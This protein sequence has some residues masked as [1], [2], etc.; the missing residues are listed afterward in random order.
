MSRRGRK[1]EISTDHDSF[2]DI[3]ANIVG[4]LIILVVLVGVRAKHAPVSVSVPGPKPAGGKSASKDDLE[5]ERALRQDLIDMQRRGIR[6]A[7]EAILRDRQRIA[8]AMR[9]SAT[10]RKIEED[11]SQ[12]DAQAQAEYDLQLK[13]AEE[14]AKL[15]EAIR[16]SIFA[17]QQKEGAEP[18]ELEFNSTPISHTVHGR[19]LHLLLQD[20]RVV[21]VPF[22]KLVEQL[23]MEFDRKVY[24]LQHQRLFTDK[25]G[26]IDGF[27]LR[28]TLERLDASPELYMQTGRSG[29]VPR[30]RLVEFL[31]VSRRLGETV[32]V[33]IV[34]G[35][36]LR[37]TLKRHR[38]DLTTVTIWTYPD[39]FANYQRLKNMLYQLGFP[40]AARP[41]QFGVPISA[42]PEGSH[43][44]AQYSHTPSRVQ[45]RKTIEKRNTGAAQTTNRPINPRIDD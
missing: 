4:I 23:E 2:L 39:G 14:Q 33:A 32:D 16:K 20:S 37:Q 8:L 13:L 21:V 45:L 27:R 7:D 5:L 42:S 38:P 22:D 3:V 10:E 18:V 25:L 43:S 12:L 44:A 31:P 40:V 15:K 17:Q 29:S 9:V 24:R 30:L 1:E 26:P 6:L 41:L 36:Q 28:Y 34:E 35:S 11:R 19:E